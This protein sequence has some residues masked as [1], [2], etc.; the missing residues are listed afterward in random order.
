M[1]SYSNT[2]L[3]GRDA[4]QLA[5]AQAY[6]FDEPRY[7]LELISR[8]HNKGVNSAAVDELQAKALLNLGAH[9]LASESAQRIMQT[10]GASP[11]LIALLLE[12]GL[13]AGDHKNV[14]H[15]IAHAEN[16]PKLRAALLEDLAQAAHLNN[17]NSLAS[18]L[19]RELLAASPD[20]ALYL[21]R[22]GAVQ[23]K[24]GD[25]DDACDSYQQAIA[26]QPDNA[27]AYNLLANVKRASEHTHHLPLLEQGL[28]RCRSQSD[29]QVEGSA[30]LHY[31]L[32]KQHED[33]GST[34]QA[35]SHYAL[36]AKAM[37]STFFYS[38]DAVAESFA[39]TRQHFNPI[40]NIGAD[41]L[42]EYNRC[43]QVAPVFILGM[44]RT[45][46]TLI[47]RILS[48]HDQVNSM[49]ELSCFKASMKR[50]VGFQG[51]EGF[52]R[53]FYQYHSTQIDYADIGQRYLALAS[54][55]NVSGKPLRYF[56]DK[57][58]L[59]FIDLGTI[60][61]ALPNAQFIHTVRDPVAILWS[62]FKQIFTH[63]MYQH[64]YDLSECAHYIAEYL[65]MMDF[66]HQQFPGRILDV[67]YEDLVANT[68]QGVERMLSFLNLPWQDSCLQFHRQKTAVATASVSQVREPIYSRSVN[69]WQAYRDYLSPGIEYLTTQGIGSSIG[70][71]NVF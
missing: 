5:R 17:D 45:G 56:T 6:L 18:R 14:R 8:L 43:D 60:A 62:N 4:R 31:A 27:I 47:D 12:A 29:T 68:Q 7:T 16:N 23:Q 30:L 19:Y 9:L 15:W 32:G 54:P 46:S 40:H 61:R 26:L 25:M 50:S 58:P 35:F 1:K 38:A 39:V 67:K 42:H 22:L 48:S 41:E 51:G 63:G 21:T 57:Y 37:R 69:G 66:W 36:G 64:S 52:H 28:E 65:K 24:S 53:S 70:G 49:G 3:S 10:D 44:P 2:I 33:L 59:N 20:N 13:A 11:S 34:A 71:C 55:D